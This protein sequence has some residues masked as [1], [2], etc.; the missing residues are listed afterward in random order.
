M[1]ICSQCLIGAIVLAPAFSY[2]QDEQSAAS[3]ASASSR[4]WTAP[5][6][7]Q[8]PPRATSSTSTSAAANAKPLAI[9]NDILEAK[10][11]PD[12]NQVPL[13]EKSSGRVFIRDGNFNA[14]GGTAKIISASDQKFGSGQGIEIS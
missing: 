12:S 11:S 3:S 13:T 2:A 8:E 10:L 1:S 9:S 6:V 7:Q 5:R 14:T 4:Y